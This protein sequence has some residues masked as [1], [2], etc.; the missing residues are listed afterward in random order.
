MHKP[1]SFTRRR[2]VGGMLRGALAAAVAPRF[3]PMRLLAGETAP[4]KKIQLAHIGTGNQGVQDMRGFLVESDTQVVAVCDVNRGSGGYRNADQFL[5]QWWANILDL[6]YL[7]PKE[8][9]LTA[10]D[11]I[12]RHCWRGLMD[13]PKHNQRVFA[14]QSERGLLNCAWPKG[15]RPER[16]ILY[17]DEVWTGI[18][19]EVAA[20]LIQEDKVEQGFQIIKA[21]RDRYTGNQRNPWCEIE[22]GGHYT[23]AMSSYSLLTSA[24]GFTYNAATQGITFAP[25][26]TPDNLKVFFTAAQGYGLLAQKRDASKQSNTVSVR[27]GELTLKRLSLG[28]HGGSGKQSTVKVNREAEYKIRA[29]DTACHILFSQPLTLKPGEDLEIEIA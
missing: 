12:H 25:H 27:Q 28:L 18:E 17:C 15:G 1:K 8:H 3:V 19:Y 29:D 23:R 16:P 22:C 14:E 4:S 5:G 11:A 10:L 13:L 9:V 6:G 20:L 21:A 2:F 7:L 24:A 26:V